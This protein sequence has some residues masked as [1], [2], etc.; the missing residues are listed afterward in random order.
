VTYFQAL[1]GVLTPPTTNQLEIVVFGPGT[2]ECVLLHL[3]DGDWFVVDSC[4]YVGSE[5]PVAS[6]Y[7]S[8]IGVDY[9]SA[10][11]QILAT[12]WHDDHIRGLA[13]LVKNCPEAK[14]AISAALES[15]Q[16]FQ[17]VLE[18]DESRKLVSGTS[19]SNEFAEIL[20][21]MDKKNRVII[22]PD[23]YVSE[24]KIVFRGGYMKRAVVEALSPSTAAETAM[25]VNS[26]Q[27]LSDRPALPPS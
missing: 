1:Q 8:A 20:D 16:F 14:L 24:N 25:K 3:G 9:T 22:G 5:N 21:I 7:L 15:D 18:I 17:L 4:R 2:G 26:P 19:T 6:E 12:H 23:S 11:S 10:I 27:G 13:Q